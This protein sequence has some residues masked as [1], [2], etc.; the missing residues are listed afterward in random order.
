MSFDKKGNQYPFTNIQVEPG[1]N[2]GLT[3]FGTFL[4]KNIHYPKDARQ[5]KI[6]GLVIVT[7]IIERDGSLTDVHVVRGLEKSLDDEAVRVL[8]ISPAWIPASEYGRPVRVQYT[9]PIR[10]RL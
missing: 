2:G 6:Q 9:V 3:A 4:S 7:F 1:F 5:H 10:Y 8:K